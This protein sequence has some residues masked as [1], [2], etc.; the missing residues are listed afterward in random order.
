MV[1]MVL[2]NNMIMKAIIIVTLMVEHSMMFEF[3]E[4]SLINDWAW[5]TNFIIHLWDN[6]FSDYWS[7]LINFLNSLLSDFWSWNNNLSLDL[8]D[9]WLDNNFTLNHC[10]FWLELYLSGYLSDFWL[11]LKDFSDDSWFDSLFDNLSNWSRIN[12]LVKLEWPTEITKGNVVSTLLSEVA[13]PFGN[14]SWSVGSSNLL[15]DLT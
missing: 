4:I 12:W 1:K 3:S 10:G 11:W 6:N 7:W 14:I 5:R 15:E 9:F 2:T 8:S 13:G